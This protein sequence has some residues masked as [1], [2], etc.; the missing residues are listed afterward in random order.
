MCR[1]ELAG[2][3]VLTTEYSI[4]S[5]LY[6]R[7]IYPSEDFTTVKKWDMPLLVTTD[8]EVKAY[9]KKIMGQLHSTD[10]TSLLK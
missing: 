5:I 4:N 10:F 2:G 8:S 7:G 9:I 6:Q 3:T 1:V